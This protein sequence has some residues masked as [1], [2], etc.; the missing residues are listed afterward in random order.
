MI[1]II[2]IICFAFSFSKETMRGHEDVI[3]KGLDIKAEG[4]CPDGWMSYRHEVVG[5][6]FC[7]P[8][9]WG[10][11]KTEPKE[12]V[13]RLADLLEDY[14]AS[15]NEYRDSFIVLFDNNE[16]IALRVFNENYGGERYAGN[17]TATGFVDNISVLKENAAICN[18]EKNYAYK[19]NYEVRIKETYA[20][21]GSGIKTAINDTQEASNERIDTSVLESFAYA[22]LANGYFDHALINH[23]YG[24][25]I[26]LGKEYDGIDAMLPDL[27][28]GKE[29]FDREEDDFTAF[30]KSIKAFVPEERIHADFR[31]AEDED[32]RITSIR[33]Y[34]YLIGSG[35]LEEAFAM[36]GDGGN[37]ED[38]VKRYEDA[39]VAEPYDFEDKGENMFSFSVRYQ[40]HNEMEK[41]YPVKME[42]A[43]GKLR[44]ISVEE[45]TDEQV[46]AG[47]YSASVAKRGEKEYVILRKGEEETIVDEGSNYSA[48]AKA[49]GFGESFSDV[50][51]SPDGRYLMYSSS[52]YEYLTSSIYDIVEKKIVMEVPGT[53]VGNSFGFTPDGRYFYL[54][55]SSG[56]YEGDAGK[57]FSVPGF[58][59]VFDAKKDGGKSYLTNMCAY[60]AQRNAIIFTA[61]D[62][63]DESMAKSRE[64]VF[65]LE[66]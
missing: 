44:T 18:Y 59:Q 8:A 15:E 19:G 46:F 30:V 11:V 66:K 1:L 65:G 9:E 16:D 57:A 5:I 40:D 32:G 56:I 49:S 35:R 14:A 53:E 12:P 20:E 2:V 38:F 33:E 37:Y 3:R 41:E 63:V 47:E 6:S 21:C 51:F 61:S 26:K 62:P 22:K 13:T 25:I 24:D 34:Y 39:Y 48:E 43:E 4:E 45:S 31:A 54:C 58:E 50:A 29:E 60:D 28:I 52:D 64:A 23:V 36:N 55:A 42:A 7:Y 17:P 10:S 27:G